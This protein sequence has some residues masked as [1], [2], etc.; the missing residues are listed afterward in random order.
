MSKDLNTEVSLEYV[1][2]QFEDWRS[3]RVKR[4]KTPDYLWKLAAPLLDRYGLNKITKAL[5]VNHQQLKNY[6]SIYLPTFK[7]LQTKP[8]FI[9]CELPLAKEACTLEF[10]CKKGSLVKINGLTPAHMQ[11]LVSLFLG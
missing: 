9:A 5:R 4:E 2:Q 11:P 8:N 1:V 10:T 7:A 3:N 6:T